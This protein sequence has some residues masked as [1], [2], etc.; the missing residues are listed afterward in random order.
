MFIAHMSI[1]V[2]YCRIFFERALADINIGLPEHHIL[3]YLSKNDTVNQDA[4]AKHYSI[5]KGTIAK[6]MN[7][8][9]EKGLIIRTDN[10]NNKREKQITLSDKGY[11]ILSD[12]QKTTDEWYSSVFEGL[13]KDE[14]DQLSG[15]LEKISVNA[16]NVVNERKINH[17]QAIEKE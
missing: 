1:I 9:E 16:V 2:R 10:P 8:L 5:D 12:M 7:K 11:S 3:I 6:S 13:S 14:I 17:D 15:I 4:I